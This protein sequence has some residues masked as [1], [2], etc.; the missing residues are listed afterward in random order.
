MQPDRTAVPDYYGSGVVLD[1]SGPDPHELPCRP[2]RRTSI[3]RSA[4]AGRPRDA[5]GVEG[6][7][8]GGVGRHYAAD[9]RSDLAVLKPDRPTPPLPDASPSAAGEDLKKGSFVVSLAHPYAAGYR[10][11]SASASWGIVSNL[12]RRPPADSG[13][14]SGRASNAA[15]PVSAR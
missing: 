8:R 12:R 2:R 14:E 9:N 3:S 11:G 13:N 4:S 5:N 6:P 7:P 10:D 15:E 1:P